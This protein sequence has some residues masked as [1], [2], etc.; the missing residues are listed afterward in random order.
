M[1]Q[2]ILDVALELFAKNGYTGTSTQDIGDRVGL[3]KTSLYYYFRSKEEILFQVVARLRERGDLRMMRIESLDVPADERLAAAIRAHCREIRDHRDE[4]QVYLIESRHVVGKHRAE[5]ARFHRAYEHRL[6][7]LI[8]AGQ[9]EGLFDPAL[10]PLIVTNGMLAMLNGLFN[11]RRS[12]DP[13]YM[14]NSTE[15]YVR[16]ILAGLRPQAPGVGT[17]PPSGKRP[18]KRR[19]AAV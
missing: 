13:E 4:A 10:D 1:D 15:T 3:D 2:E 19:P 18:P 14:D 6:Q 9:E 8:V 5:L 16:L 11:T 12:V 7:Q 17:R